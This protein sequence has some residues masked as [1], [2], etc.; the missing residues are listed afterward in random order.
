[1]S[2]KLNKLIDNDIKVV[3][4]PG[5]HDIGYTAS[6][7]FI[8]D[9]YESVDNVSKDEFKK[10]YHNC[11]YDDALYCDS[12]SLSYVY[13]MGSNLWLLMVDSNE[14]NSKGSV[15]DK[16]LK[17]IRKILK[18]ANKK[19]V[20]VISVT[21]QNLLVHNKLFNSGFTLDNNE[22]LLEL[23]KKY[24]VKL[25]LSGHMHVQSIMEEEGVV[26]IATSSL[27]L[28]DLHYGVIDINNSNYVY[29]T[30]NLA[31]NEI[32][33]VQYFKDVCMHKGSNED[34]CEI[35]YE[36]FMGKVDEKLLEKVKNSYEEKN[37]LEYKYLESI[38]KTH[39]NNYFEGS[40]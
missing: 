1:L 19:G 10:I 5:N 13:D 15:S 24:G 33:S 37:N 29:Q 31:F 3:V 11:G 30:Y 22:E 6:A 38:E 25:N 17:W 18:E 35:N 27:T 9:S 34:F 28:G 26:D 12:E 20:K 7:K 40:L 16:T 8:G 4:I 14:V 32:D 39:N 23:Y 36:Y 21:H 2:N